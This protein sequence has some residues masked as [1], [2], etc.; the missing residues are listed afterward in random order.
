M[1]TPPVSEATAEEAAAIAEEDN[2][3]YNKEERTG[4]LVAP[5]SLKSIWDDP[6]LEV[7]IVNVGSCWNFSWCKKSFECKNATKALAH[8]A[9]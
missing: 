8:L 3:T 7:T 6:H 4:P 1:D 9:R 5:Q 2:L